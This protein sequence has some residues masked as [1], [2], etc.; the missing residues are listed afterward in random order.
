[1]DQ[2]NVNIFISDAQ[3]PNL[4]YLLSLLLDSETKLFRNKNFSLRLH[5]PT[6]SEPSIDEKVNLDEF[7]EQI[8]ESAFSKLIEIKYGGC[9]SDLQ[10]LFKDVH[11]VLLLDSIPYKI[12]R[13][14]SENI[15]NHSNHK[16]NIYIYNNL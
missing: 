16:C 7:V 14:Y 10:Q 1:M 6:P 8:Q 9:G 12:L 2:E 5:N 4:Y 11:L 13:E 15:N 3:N